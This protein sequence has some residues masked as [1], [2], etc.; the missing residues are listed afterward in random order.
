MNDNNFP[1]LPNAKL[2]LNPNAASY[3]PAN[4][5]P[6]YQISQLQS[7]NQTH[8]NPL[9]SQNQ[10]HSNP[11]QSQ[12]QTHSN[13][14]QSQNQTHSNQL[15]NSQS[16]IY[17]P[18]HFI[19]M[20]K[21]MLE[22][23]KIIS[24]APYNMELEE[25]NKL[26]EAIRNIQR[27][28]YI[29]NEY[30][31]KISAFKEHI[32]EIASDAEIKYNNIISEF[33]LHVKKLHESVNTRSNSPSLGSNNSSSTHATNASSLTH[34]SHASHNLSGT[35]SNNDNHLSTE[36][37][38]MKNKKGESIPVSINNLTYANVTVF[39]NSI[40][41][42]VLRSLI[43]VQKEMLNIYDMIATT[44]DNETQSLN[45]EYKEVAPSVELPVLSVNTLDEV[46]L[47]S[48]YYVKSIDK[49]AI[50]LN[51]L[52]LTSSGIGHV[53]NNNEKPYGVIEC[54]RGKEC[55]RGDA[56]RF[57][58]NDGIRNF[59]NTSFIYTY[60]S[61]DKSPGMRHIGERDNIKPDLALLDESEITYRYAQTMHDILIAMVIA[62]NASRFAPRS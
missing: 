17:V 54:N 36:Q 35:G 9:Q 22:N 3:L 1:P 28:N 42:E 41:S 53:F 30:V 56:C 48:L 58:H 55:L 59:T 4:S 47:Y 12:N 23:N 18:D 7:Q 11:L 8:S 40:N 20:Y 15:Q 13:P 10:T 31:K 50:N 33:K 45:Y 21:T 49:M 51:G 14:L 27:I 37:I 43:P 38:I 44:S 6:I 46:P 57:Y 39:S 26:K 19:A 16:T 60:S 52:L 32:I 29:T 61:P 25:L 62:Q 24:T 5:D 2:S 34:T